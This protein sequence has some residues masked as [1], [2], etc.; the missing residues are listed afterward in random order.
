MDKRQTLP[1]LN[2]R[3][4]YLEPTITEA[5]IVA[6]LATLLTALLLPVARAQSAPP[7]VKL[8][9][10]RSVQTEL[11]RCTSSLLLI[12][13]VVTPDIASSL[14]VAAERKVAVRYIVTER[15]ALPAI[16]KHPNIQI[17]FYAGGS[18]F[19]ICKGASFI[20]TSLLYTAKPAP[21]TPSSAVHIPNFTAYYETIFE[22]LWTRAAK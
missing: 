3:R 21:Q 19:A 11:N 2:R 10:T 7:T 6:V 18:S 15:K 9:T 4:W 5:L 22:Q 14:R 13:P 1:T 20:A 16:L 8:E 12:S 17:R